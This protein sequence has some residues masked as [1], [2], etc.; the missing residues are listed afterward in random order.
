LPV[1][2]TGRG[3]VDLVSREPPKRLN[4]G[5]LTVDGGAVQPP[6]AIGPGIHPT[7]LEQSF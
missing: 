1:E 6:G 7:P 5:I 2:L 3:A 4:R